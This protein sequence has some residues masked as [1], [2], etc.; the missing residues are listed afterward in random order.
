ME[1]LRETHLLSFRHNVIAAAITLSFH[2]FANTLGGMLLILHN[3]VTTKS[4]AAS[5]STLDVSRNISQLH[6]YLITNIII[7]A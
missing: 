3:L 7:T 4:F 6:I 1:D 5:L 2:R